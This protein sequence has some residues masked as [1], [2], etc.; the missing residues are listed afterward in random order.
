MRTLRYATLL[1]ALAACAALGHRPAA[2]A[3]EKPDDKGPMLAHYVFFTLKERTD[4][5]KKKLVAACKKH[6][7]KHEGEVFFTVGTLA[8]DLKGEL[9]DRDFDVALTIVF[10][11]KAAH[12]TYQP[13]RRHLDFIK[14]NKGLWT[15]VRVFDSYNTK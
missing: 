10:K 7:T 14:E 12:D 2:V 1:A 4:A 13:N 9:N 15:K 3:D 8:E 6:L 11:N 5:N